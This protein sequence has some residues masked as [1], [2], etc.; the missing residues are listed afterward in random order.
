MVTLLAGVVSMPYSVRFCH[1]SLALFFLNWLIEGDLKAKAAWLAQHPLAWLLPAFFFVHL[2]GLFYTKDLA[3]GWNNV[4]KKISMLLL[5]LAMASTARYSKTEL[6]YI[7]SA[8]VAACFVGT[9]VCIGHSLAT[10][11]HGMTAENFS[12]PTQSLFDNLNPGAA[13]AWMN[14]SYLGLSSGIG[15]H[16]TYLGL[17]LLMDMFL[18]VYMSRQ[19]RTI[20]GVLLV[21]LLSYFSVFIIFL[22]SRVIIVAAVVMAIATV[23]F[24]GQSATKKAIA[25]VA[26]LALF[27]VVLY[28]NPVSRYRGL[29]E[30]F[31]IDHRQIPNYAT[32]STDIRLSLLWLS[33]HAAVGVNPLIGAGTGATEQSIHALT[34][35]HDMTN[36]LNTYDP[37]NQFLHTFISLGIVGLG[38]LLLVFIAPLIVA[39]QKK[40]YLHI[41]F[42]G[43]FMIV[44]LTESALELQKGI[45]FFSLFGSLLLFHI[46]EPA[47]KRREFSY[48]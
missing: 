29:Q 25:A 16:P 15:M 10:T 11:M 45:V 44:C 23:I 7:F 13:L 5:P 17:Y 35:D 43:A 3:A 28:I 42:S 34:A 31:S 1:V 27:T 40:S 37:H 21:G 47:A 26:I 6:A 4:E 8:F 22:S 18:L 36:I 46:L 38:T 12:A 20:S 41:L 19:H 33:A 14:F 32:N 48:A 9:L 30:L 39:W 24:L 2:A